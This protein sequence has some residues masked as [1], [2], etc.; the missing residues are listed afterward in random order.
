MYEVSVVFKAYG[1]SYVYTDEYHSLT[2]ECLKPQVSDGYTSYGDNFLPYINCA[3]VYPQA[4][5][6]LAVGTTTSDTLPF[7][8]VFPNNGTFS[9]L[10]YEKLST[11][12]VL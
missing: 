10:A 4:N 7:G 12:C 11:K 9:G 5:I 3:G 2:A 6:T 8:F 1:H